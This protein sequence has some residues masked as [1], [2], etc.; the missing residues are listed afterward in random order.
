MVGEFLREAVDVEAAHA[1]D[2][3]AE[4]L[5]AAQAARQVPQISAA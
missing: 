5:P 4:I 1:A 3:L 2:I